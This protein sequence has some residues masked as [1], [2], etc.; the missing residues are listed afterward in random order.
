[1]QIKTSGQLRQNLVEMIRDVRDGKLEPSRA[2]AASKLAA[3]INENFYAEIKAA[4]LDL[5]KGITPN[6][7]GDMPINCHNVI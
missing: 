7:L 5:Q 6:V 2:S 3:Q 4:K 1:M